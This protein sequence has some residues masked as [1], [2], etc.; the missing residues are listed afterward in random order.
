LQ[1]QPQKVESI[2]RAPVVDDRQAH[3]KRTTRWEVAVDPVS[4]LQGWEVAAAPV[5]VQ[6]RASTELQLGVRGALNQPR[7]ID[8]DQDRTMDRRQRTCDLDSHGAKMVR[9]PPAGPT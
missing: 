3:R 5:P 9:R 2:L 1:G 7:K 6:S 8:L 4:A